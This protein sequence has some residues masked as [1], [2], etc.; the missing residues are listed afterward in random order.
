MLER[1]TDHSTCAALLRGGSLSFHAACR[2]LPAALR[3]D[4]VALYAFCRVADDAV[5][6]S[7]SKAEAV[8]QLSTRLDRAYA[9]SPIDDPVDREF[10]ALIARHTIPR[11]LP[12][13]LIEGLVWDSEARRYQDHSALRAYAARVAGAVGAMMT[14]LM[15]VRDAPALAAA[16]DLGVAMQLTNIARDVGE[17]ARAGRL[18]LPLDAL[19]HAGLDPDRFLAT[20]EFSPALGRVIAEL[21]AE[22]ERL[23]QRGFAGIAALPLRC[24]PAIAA[25]GLIYREIGRDL[26]STGYDSLTRRARVSG[27][28]KALLAAS[29]LGL[30]LWRRP[31]TDGAPLPETAFLVEAVAHPRAEPVGP[32]VRVLL[33]IEKLERE[34]RR[35]RSESACISGNFA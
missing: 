32:G 28:R 33:L 1:D 13:A 7:D 27:Q 12:D 14:L 4:V 15:G 30:A 20:P 22:A 34:D 8:A 5:D 24:R 19:V 26:A 6:F 2:L 18:Y 35:K 31:V 25:A 11:T 21:L 16:C 29:G 23:Y 9:G 3:R 10:A 17:D